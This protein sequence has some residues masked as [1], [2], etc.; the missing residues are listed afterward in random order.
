MVNRIEVGFWGGVGVESWRV[1]FF[2]VVYG[3]FLRERGYS[4]IF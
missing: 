2:L 4:V 3:I 1:R